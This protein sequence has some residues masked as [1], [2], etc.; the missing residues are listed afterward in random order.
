MFASVIS[1]FK[2][3][4]LGLIVFGEKVKIWDMIGMTPPG[5]YTWTQQNKI[6][7]C[8]GVF[9][10]SNAVENALIQTGAFEVEL[11]GMP[12][13]SKLKTGRVP[14][15]SELFEII[16]NQMQLSSQNKFPGEFKVK[17]EFKVPGQFK[18]PEE[19][20]APETPEENPTDSTEDEV[21]DEDKSDFEMNEEK[22][23]PKEEDEFSEI[24]RD[25]EN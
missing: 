24:D 15:G 23:K 7:A 4:A 2:W 19:Y 20:S 13:W 10:F 8:M 1:T 9:F 18:V 11:N 21:E 17:D 16:E 3:V 22:P 6:V 25:T 12:I 5:A 14:Q